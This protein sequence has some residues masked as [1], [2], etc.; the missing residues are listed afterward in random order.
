MR[1]V[2]GQAVSERAAF[3]AA[4][5]AVPDDDVARLVYADWL[6][7]QANERDARHAAMIRFQV[8]MARTPHDHAAKCRATERRPG[9]GPRCERCALEREDRGWQSWG[10]DNLVPAPF[11]GRCVFRRG[12]ADAVACPADVWTASGRFL[13]DDH[14]VRSVLLIRPAGLIV[15]R[16]AHSLEGIARAVVMGVHEESRGPISALA[17]PWMAHPRE[18]LFCDAPGYAVRDWWGRDKTSENV[19]RGL[20]PD[21]FR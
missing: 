6:D 18:L 19:L 13:R 12:L 4:I 3:L 8:R 17:R 15:A 10:H 7:E 1:L 14:P 16:L 9:T 21:L 11:C 2:R 5:K 20:L